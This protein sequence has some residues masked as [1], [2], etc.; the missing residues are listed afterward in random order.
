M[1]YDYFVAADDAM[2]EEAYTEQGGG[3]CAG[4]EE[5]AVKGA[6]PHDL[7]PIEISLTGRTAEELEADPRR[8]QLVG[9]FDED[10]QAEME[11]AVVTLTDACRDALAVA[12][13]D[14]LHTAVVAFAAAQEEPGDTSGLFPFLKELAVLAK[15]AAANGH[16]LYCQIVW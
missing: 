7:L 10:E 12:E 6:D 4:Y 13:D 15:G 1:L 8:C 3:R 2:A 16:H 14:A 9:E 5:L 11:S